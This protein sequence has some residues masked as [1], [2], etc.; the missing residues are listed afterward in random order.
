MSDDTINSDK[1]SDKTLPNEP[2][3]D[4]L[5]ACGLS[6]AAFLNQEAARAKAAIV[7]SLYAIEE[8]VRS[9]ADFGG[10]AREH[11]WMAAGIASL[12][13]FAAAATMRSS[14][15]KPAQPPGDNC[16]LPPSDGVPQEKPSERPTRADTLGWLVTP[17]SILLQTVAA[18]FIAAL[19]VGASAPARIAGQPAVADAPSVPVGATESRIEMGQGTD[20]EPD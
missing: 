7:R 12:A 2:P 17:L 11:P 15:G 1:P 10:W 16:E 13:G 8:D 19:I 3:P 14:Q 6:E 20:L 4:P 5:A 9:L 18:K